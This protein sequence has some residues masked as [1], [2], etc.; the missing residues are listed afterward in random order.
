MGSAGVLLKLVEL[1][2]EIRG[3]QGELRRESGGRSGPIIEKGDCSVALFGS[4]QVIY[5]IYLLLMYIVTSKP[6]RMSLYSGV[7][8]FMM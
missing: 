3:D 6:K 7:S 1:P 2:G 8:H 4:Q 5:W